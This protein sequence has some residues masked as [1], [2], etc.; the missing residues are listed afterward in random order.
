M[1]LLGLGARGGT[2]K[3]A[4]SRTRARFLV[5]AFTSDWLFPISQSKE[6]VQAL[7]ANLA[8]VTYFEIESDYGHDAFLL[9]RDELTNVVQMFLDRVETKGESRIVADPPQ[10]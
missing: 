5:V 2:L 1:D 6:I 4:F 9:E 7:R 8:D 3:Q 10:I